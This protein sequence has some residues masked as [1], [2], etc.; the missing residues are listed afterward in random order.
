MSM[1]FKKL[2]K[3]VSGKGAVST[4]ETVTV[5]GNLGKD[6]IIRPVGDTG[7]MAANMSIALGDD[8]VEDEEGNLVRQTAWRNLVVFAEAASRVIKVVESFRKGTAI[9]ATGTIRKTSWIDSETGEERSGEEVEVL[10]IRE[11]KT[12]SRP[13]PRATSDYALQAAAAGSGDNADL[14]DNGPF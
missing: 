13:A 6:P 7:R 12:A 3:R 8:W 5:S 9:I 10:S 2:T 1:F 14:A 4:K 11:D